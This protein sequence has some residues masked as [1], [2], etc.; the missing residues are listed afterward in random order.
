M[1]SYFLRGIAI[2]LLFGL[3]A[4]AVGAM[5][6]QRTLNHGVKDGLITGLGSSVADCLYACIGVFG[7][8][9]ISDFLLKH[10]T[11]INIIG[12]ALILFMGIRL[13]ARKSAK[14]EPTTNVTN[15]TKFFMSSFAIGIT[16]PAAILTFLLAFSIFGILSSK[17][18]I[19]QGILL[20]V[21]VFIGTF[22]WW[23]TLSFGT[24]AI[25][26]KAKKINIC[27]M[28]ML[29]GIILITFGTVVFLQ[30]FF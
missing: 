26:K 7:L 16:N 21:G 8:T 4:G 12:S 5:T 9:F 2:G 13:I 15:G 28:N 18:L 19:T 23:G 11:I 30:T 14:C 3:P 24:E 25:K 29:F 1:I 22:I 6:V 17:A 10:Q 27:K 20:V